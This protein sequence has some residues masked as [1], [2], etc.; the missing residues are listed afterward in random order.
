MQDRNA[1]MSY[2]LLPTRRWGKTTP[3]LPAVE[4]SITVGDPVED[5]GLYRVFVSHLLYQETTKTRKEVIR[6][7]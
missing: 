1:R 5:R 3:K 2:G 4:S 6:V 7:R